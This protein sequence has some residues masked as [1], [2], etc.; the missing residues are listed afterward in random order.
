MTPI[1]PQ[2]RS[3]VHGMVKVLVVGSPRRGHALASLRH[4]RSHT[5]DQTHHYCESCR[6]TKRVRCSYANSRCDQ[7]TCRLAPIWLRGAVSPGRLYSVEHPLL[8]NQKHRTHP[9]GQQRSGRH[10]ERRDRPCCAQELIPAKQVVALG[11]LLWP[12]QQ[13]AVPDDSF[14]AQTAFRF[15]KYGALCCRTSKAGEGP[16]RI[17]ARLRGRDRSFP[18]TEDQRNK[19]RALG[20]TSALHSS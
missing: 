6:S 5:P 11:H 12:Q 19:N 16:S 8:A 2:S 14:A 20:V 4:E 15:Q 9:D 13:R 10:C 18:T 1:L 17:P 3:I 7:S